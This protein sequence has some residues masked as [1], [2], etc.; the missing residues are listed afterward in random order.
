MYH[1]LAYH[2]VFD[3]ARFAFNI[4]KGGLRCFVGD[5]DLVVDV[6]QFGDVRAAKDLV[7]LNRP[8]Y[9]EFLKRYPYPAQAK[10]WESIE[11]GFLKSIPDYGKDINAVWRR[12]V[13]AYD[14][15]MWRNFK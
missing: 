14:Q 13:D 6:V 9:E 4:G 10:F 2:L 8:L 1:P 7:K 5:Q 12:V 11:Q 3:L 15:P